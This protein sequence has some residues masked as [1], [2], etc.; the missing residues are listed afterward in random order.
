MKIIEIK[1]LCVSAQDKIILKDFNLNINSGEVHVVIGENGAGK[2]TLA[3]AILNNPI[4]KKESGKIIFMGEDITDLSTDKIALKKI[5]MSFQNPIEIPGIKL[6]NFLKFSKSKIEGKIINVSD[7]DNNLLLNTNKLNM[8]SELLKRDLN[9]GFSGGE[10]KKN[11]ILQMLSLN[12]RFVILDEIDSGLDF[13][14]VKTVSKGISLYK[15]NDNALLIITHNSSIL[16]NI[17]VDYVH[18]LSDGKIIKTGDISLIEEV[19]DK[20][21]VNY[22]AGEC[23]EKK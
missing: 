19:K 21:Y 4:Y 1:D 14:A 9:V 20:G 7:I 17:D 15:N 5:F 6:A 12:P 2:S 10:K 16:E 11:E 18:I 13:D 3:N 22:I 23:D 8:N